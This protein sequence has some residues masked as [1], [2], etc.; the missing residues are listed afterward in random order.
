MQNI[1]DDLNI[2]ESEFEES[3]KQFQQN[4]AISE[5]A[6]LLNH[7]S[8]LLMY[9]KEKRKNIL[10][11]AYIMTHDMREDIR[12]YLL[13]SGRRREKNVYKFRQEKVQ[14]GLLTRFI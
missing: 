13:E 14:I 11:N 4:Q 2:N 9:L 6:Q 8:Q 10:D 3:Y 7:S 1:L 5:E 12:Y